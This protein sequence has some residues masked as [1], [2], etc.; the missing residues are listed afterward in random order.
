VPAFI[1]YS[2]KDEAIYTTVC[3]ALDAAKIERWDRMTM[4]AGDSLAE[5]LREAI[6]DCEV[7][8]FI[9]TRRSI[10]SAWC[11]AELGAFWGVGKKVLMFMVDADL[12]DSAL[13]PQF[14]GTLRVGTAPELIAGVRAESESH[15]AAVANARAET[16]YRFFD[17]SG[18]YGTEKD[19]LGLLQEAER[20]FDLMGIVLMQWRKTPAFK[21][22]IVAKAAAGC[23]VRILLMDDDNPALKHLLCGD[24]EFSSVVQDLGESREYYFELSQ[25]HPKI[26][27]RRL[28]D[29]IFHFFLTRNDRRAVTIQYLS[30][31]M[32][33]AGPTWQC[34]AGSKLF[35]VATREF[36]LLWKRGVPLR[37]PSA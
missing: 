22:T 2:L 19:W 20:C 3:M 30:S 5:Q 37:A 1:S 34:P 32:W 29:G 17:S 36:E 8:V 28:P 4:A 12:D 25:E 7:C 10:E 6:R 24:Q 35:D 13:P 18:N 23:A 14:K 21:Q 26:Q 33:G 15:A 16:P 31:E 11:L 9:A 27:V